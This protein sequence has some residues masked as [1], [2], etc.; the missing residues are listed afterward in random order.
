MVLEV[1]AKA[2]R[3]QKENDTNQKGRSQISPFA[4]DII[5]YL[6]DTKNFSRELL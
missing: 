5:I 1:L 6:S 2:I 3:Q 4:D